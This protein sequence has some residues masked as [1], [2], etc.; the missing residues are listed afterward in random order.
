MRAPTAS[1]RN[2]AGTN[3][4]V[5][6]PEGAQDCAMQSQ[7][8]AS[9][10]RAPDTDDMV[11]ARPDAATVE[12]EPPRR[13][14]RLA[15]RIPTSLRPLVRTGRFTATKLLAA[16][17]QRAFEHCPGSSETFGPPRH[18]APTLKDYAREHAGDI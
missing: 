2:R 17:A 3:P 6:I 11:S 16:A 14:P 12:T 5:P 4:L 10:N 18:L 1:A 15:A 8:R 9:A 7:K 13:A